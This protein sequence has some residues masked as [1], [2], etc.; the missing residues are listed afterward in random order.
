MAMHNQTTIKTAI[1][2]VAFKANPAPDKG[3]GQ[4]RA[5]PATALGWGQV[6]EPGARSIS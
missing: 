4:V 2:K 5:N 6:R 3:S 1:E